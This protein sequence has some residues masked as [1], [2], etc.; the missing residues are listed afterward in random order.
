MLTHLKVSNYALIN[1]LEIDFREGLNSITGETG[2][3]KSI[4][5]GA[6]GLVLG[7][8]A[9][10]SVLLDSSRKCIVEATFDISNAKL[11]KFFQKNHLDWDSYTILRREISPAGKSR[12]FINDT[13]VNLSQMKVLGEALIDI[14]SQHQTLKL[15]SAEY[16]IALLDAFARQQ[17]ILADYTEKYRSYQKQLKILSQLKEDDN[18]AR[19][20]YDYSLYQLNELQEAG[21]SEHEDTKLDEELV[22]LSNAENI[23]ASL[24]QAIFLINEQENSILSQTGEVKKLISGIASLSPV[25]TTISDRLESVFVELKDILQDIHSYAEEIVVD[26]ARL[27][28]VNDRLALIHKLLQKHQVKNTGQLFTFQQELQQS[29]GFSEIRT[30]DILKLEKDIVER[31]KSLYELSEKISANRIKQIAPLEKNLVSLLNQLGI[32]EA[33]VLINIRK[34]DKLTETGM[35][36][37]EILFSA[38]KGTKPEPIAQVASGGELSRIILSFKYIL[39]DNILLASMVFDEIDTGISG[40]VAIQVGKMIKKLSGSHQV[41][42]ITH[43]PQVAA[44]GSHHYIVFKQPGS[45]YTH[46]HMRLLSPHERINE[47]AQMLGGHSPSKLIMDNARELLMS[48]A[49]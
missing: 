12:G 44:M 6:L 9:D 35:D 2:T 10:S 42:C 37:V 21:I 32:P 11:Q 33:H 26:N 18:L 4:L 48:Y 45:N 8:R 27:Q 3:G 23:Q 15:A 22:I 43:H 20:N 36:Q 1:D 7:N 29:V 19:K 40:E 31:E 41:L 28:S 13:P 30:E 46:T 14:H 17:T 39:A 16:Q 38:N 34:L 25:L 24:Q 47:I 49:T 5:L